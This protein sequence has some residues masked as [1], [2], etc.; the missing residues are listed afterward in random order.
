MIRPKP[1]I[2]ATLVATL[3]IGCQV[4]SAEGQTYYQY[5]PLTLSFT[6]PNVSELGEPNPF[7]DFRVDVTFTRA[8][9]RF[10]VP[11]YF[12]ADGNAA[13]TS[14]DA[15]DQ[16]HVNFAADEPGEW[17]YSVSFRQGKNVAV[18]AST[19]NSQRIQGVDGEL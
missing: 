2:V 7:L 3:L 1:M 19:A 15:G 11:G 16:W 17:H 5:E 12:A 14:A 9:K 4:S 10:T 13:E 6:G 8:G 18:S